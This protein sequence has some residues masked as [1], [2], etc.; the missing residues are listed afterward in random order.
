MKK[1]TCAIVRTPEDLSNYCVRV[2]DDL[3]DVVSD[4]EQY[5]GDNILSEDE[6]K[7]LMEAHEI[8]LDTSRYI[9]TGERFI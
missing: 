1:V 9:K 3:G 5:T 6:Y 8:L 4:I 7:V 2:A